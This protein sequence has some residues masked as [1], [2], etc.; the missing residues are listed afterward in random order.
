MSENTV[1]RRMA[2]LGLA[3]RRPKKPRSP[4]GQGRRPTAPDLVRRT[5][6]AVAPN[7]LWTGDV[8]MIIT[9]KAFRRFTPGRLEPIR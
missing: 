8:T 3:G 9:E 4:T 6:T 1:A 5:F 2:E 7:V